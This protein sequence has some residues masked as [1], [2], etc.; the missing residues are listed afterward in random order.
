[1]TSESLVGWN[2]PGSGGLFLNVLMAN[3]PQA[4]LSFLFLTYNG[5]Y[6]CMLM[7]KEWNDYAYERKTLRVTN[8]VR[9]QRSTYRLQLPYKYGIPLIVLSG[10]YTGSSLKACFLPEWQCSTTEWK[11]RRTRSP[12][13]DIAV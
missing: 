6:T 12:L 5:L 2:I 9:E 1:M 11:T 3:S 7:A 4:L 8:P 13:W 10:H